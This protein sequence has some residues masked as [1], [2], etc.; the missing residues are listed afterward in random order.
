[1]NVIAKRDLSIIGADIRKGDECQINIE[2]TNP[3][4]SIMMR[5]YRYGAA[6]FKEYIN[7]EHIHDDWS[8]VDHISVSEE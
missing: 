5:I 2:A 4:N 7:H 3:D 6:A 1:M 8:P